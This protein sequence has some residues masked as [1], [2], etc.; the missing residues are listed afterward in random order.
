MSSNSSPNTLSDSALHL[1]DKMSSPLSSSPRL[2]SPLP[3][4]L[5]PASPPLSEIIS[6]IFPPFDHQTNIV[7]PFNDE[8][9]RDLVFE[10]ELSSML[11]DVI[12][13]A[14]A[15][16]SARSKQESTLAAQNIEQ[17]I[18]SVIE[19]EK[20]QGMFPP[21]S[22]SPSYSTPPFHSTIVGRQRLIIM[23]PHPFILR[24]FFRPDA[25]ADYN[26]GP[27]FFTCSDRR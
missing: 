22:S 15:W 18:V 16:S 21:A 4:N 8:T 12:M 25:I 17:K 26:L 13:Q 24:T 3:T 7:K 6:Q 20:E 5:H 14:H 9:N 11:L 27:C 10:R 19:T 23:P 1:T 2:T